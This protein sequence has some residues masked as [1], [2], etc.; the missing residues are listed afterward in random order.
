MAN[1]SD[2][3]LAGRIRDYIHAVHE[4]WKV[5][6]TVESYAAAGYYDSGEPTD[7]T[8][9]IVVEC[10]PGNLVIVKSDETTAS[11]FKTK[12]AFT[13]AQLT[14]APEEIC[15]ELEAQIDEMV[16][17]PVPFGFGIDHAREFDTWENEGGNGNHR[18]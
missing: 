15:R 2:T 10:Y 12:Y 9:S 6:V 4:T 5:K 18:S 3:V 7:P 13:N 8:C 14:D 1:E 11:G 17:G 16:H